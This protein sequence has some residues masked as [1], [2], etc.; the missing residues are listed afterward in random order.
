MITLIADAARE[1]LSASCLVVPAQ[2]SSPTGTITYVVS[3][4]G[5]TDMGP[6]VDSLLSGD[7]M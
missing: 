5:K 1:M 2:M 6:H 3:A 4:S 7:T